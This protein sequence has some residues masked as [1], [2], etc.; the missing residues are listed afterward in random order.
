VGART[1]VTADGSLPQLRLTAFGSRS[2]RPQRSLHADRAVAPVDGSL[3]EPMAACA[4]RSRWTYR[5]CRALRSADAPPGRGRSRFWRSDHGRSRFWR[6]D[7][8]RSRFRRS[9]HGRSRFR[10][11]DHGRSR[12]RRSDHGRSRSDHGRSRSEPMRRDRSGESDPA[13]GPGDPGPARPSRA[14]ER[15]FPAS[16]TS[17]FSRPAQVSVAV[18]LDNFVSSSTRMDEEE[19]VCRMPPRAARP[20]STRSQAEGHWHRSQRHARAPV[21]ATVTMA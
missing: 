11:S 20:F 17:I 10:R 16:L 15:G 21:T 6:S 1:Q 7:H 3:G 9:D 2:A 8:D 4:L 5:D 18:L 14:G 12:F 13:G 19:Q